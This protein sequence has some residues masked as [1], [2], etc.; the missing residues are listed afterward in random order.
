MSPSQGQ[1]SGL[2][3]PPPRWL[4]WGNVHG[5]VVVLGPHL[6]AAA[7]RFSPRTAGSPR[8]LS[9]S[10]HPAPTPELLVPLAWGVSWELDIL[11]LPADS[12]VQPELGTIVLMIPLP[13]PL[14]ILKGH[15]DV[16]SCQRVFS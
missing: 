8:R 10:C 16:V 5:S 7:N 3:S 2:S 15:W 14:K 9:E 13:K 12:N 6:E 11:K 1:V 4:P